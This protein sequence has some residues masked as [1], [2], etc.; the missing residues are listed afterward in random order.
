[1]KSVVIV[2]SQESS[3]QNQ[4]TQEIVMT[5]SIEV[6]SERHIRFLSTMINKDKAFRLPCTIKKENQIEVEL[7]RQ[8]VQVD[9]ESDMNVIFVDMTRKLKSTLHSL[10]N[11]EF[12]D[13]FMRTANYREIILFN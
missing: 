13:L 11:I 3:Q 12:F 7:K 10:S 4:F 5:S 1:M 9:Q 8:Y 2:A 6:E